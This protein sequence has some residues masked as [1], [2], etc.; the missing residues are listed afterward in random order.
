MNYVYDPA[1]AGPLHEAISYPSAVV[2]ADKYMTEA[3]RRSVFLNPPAGT[4]LVEFRILT[5]PEDDQLSEAFAKATQ[6]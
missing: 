2:G 1:V 3:G 5:K 4:D 6:Q